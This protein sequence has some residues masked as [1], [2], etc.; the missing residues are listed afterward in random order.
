MR[1]R[2][3]T[4]II[5]CPL[6]N[7]DEVGNLDADVEDPVSPALQCTLLDLGGDLL[8]E[9]IQHLRTLGSG[10]DAALANA[11]AS[12]RPMLHAALGTGVIRLNLDAGAAHLEW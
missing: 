7:E 12:C 5:T 1:R 3:E 2:S 4:G 8:V 10:A 6:H 11:T 9:I